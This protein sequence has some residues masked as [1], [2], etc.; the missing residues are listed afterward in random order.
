VILSSYDHYMPADGSAS[1]WQVTPA[2]W[3]R[4]LRRTYALLSGAGLS[5]VVIRGTP[6]PGFDVPACLSRRA[7]GS[8]FQF[9]GCEYSLNESLSP[10]AVRAQD[11]AARGLPGIAF[12]D[13]ND[14]FCAGDRCAPIRHGAIVFRD[15]DHLTA[16]FSRAVAPIFGER[17]EAARRALARH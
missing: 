1:S 10:L 12:V 14:Q 6:Q 7:N 8:P 9:R 15:D 4:G 2:L 17:V 13:M 11:D 16:T 5:T 3:Q